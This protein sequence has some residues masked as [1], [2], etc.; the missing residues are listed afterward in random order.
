MLIGLFEKYF[1]CFM[2]AADIATFIIQKK[3]LGTKAPMVET[4]DEKR[5]HLGPGKKF[6]SAI[7]GLK[8]ISC[9]WLH[10]KVTSFTSK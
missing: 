2:Q 1:T 9:K 8:T 5:Q 4:V 7:G 3:D 6:W 10:L